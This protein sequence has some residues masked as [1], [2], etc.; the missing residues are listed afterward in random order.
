VF[1]RGIL[2]FGS[3]HTLLM[4]LPREVLIWESVSKVVPKVHAVN[5][6]LGRSG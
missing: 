4:G 2:S 1:I 3:E 5:L 6:S